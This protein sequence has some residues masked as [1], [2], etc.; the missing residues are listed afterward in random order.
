M[1]EVVPGREYLLVTQLVPNA[2]ELLDAEVDDRL[3]DDAL[4]QVRRM[5]V[6]GVAHRDVKP[7]NTLVRD[8]RV[9]LIDLAFG[10]LRPST[11]R[12]AVDLGNMMLTLGLRVGSP[13]VRPGCPDLRSARGRGSL[14]RLR[15]GHH[16]RQLH[17]PLDLFG[18]DLLAEFRT[19]APH[20]PPI[21]IQRWS[22]RRVRLRCSPPPRPWPPW[23]SSSP[24]C[25][26]ASCSEVA[27]PAGVSGA[28][29]RRPAGGA[30]AAGAPRWAG[31]GGGP[32]AATR[33]AAI[34]PAAA[35]EARVA[36][37]AG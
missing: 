16:P 34:R 23:S 19:L 28:G 32:A 5:W 9:Y 25:A 12:Q 36:R 33:S 3:I 37:A 27:G 7:S 17:R 1:V 10:E 18:T 4:G 31:P 15:L 14:R 20:H 35:G 30:A 11:W 29:C 8:G 24:T 21:A 26:P 22:M 6:A 2:Q 13:G